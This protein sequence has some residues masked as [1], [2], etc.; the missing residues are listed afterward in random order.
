MT[1]S[2]LLTFIGIIILSFALVGISL[3][4]DA[5]PQASSTPGSQNQTNYTHTPPT[6]AYVDSTQSDLAVPYEGEL[7]QASPGLQGSAG[8]SGF[9]NPQAVLW[10]NGPLVTHP[11]A[12]AGM[13]ASR[14]QTDLGMNTLGF[15]HQYIQNY[16]M[17]DDFTISGPS[18]WNIQQITFF[19]YQTNSPISPSPFTGVYYQIWNGSPDDPGSSIVFGDLTTNRLVSSIFT[20][21]QRDSGTSNCAN[22][23]YIFAN[24][25]SAG[26]SLAPGTYWIEWM[27]D[28]N[29]SFSGPW[30]PPITILGQTT[31]GNALQYTTAWAPAL[32]SGTATQQGM[33]F[34]IEGLLGEPMIEVTPMDLHATQA[35]N[36]VTS[37]PLQICN[38]GGDTLNWSITEGYANKL[39]V[40]LLIETRDTTQTLQKA[41]NE[42]GIAYDLFQGDNWTGLDFSSYSVVIV[43]MDG[44]GINQPSL[45]KI[46]TD[47][48]DAG[49]RLVFV[50]GTCMQNFALGVNDFLVLNDTANYCWKIPNTPHFAIVDPANPLAFG[51]P[52]PYNFASSSAAYYQIRVNDPN[53][54]VVAINGD[55]FPNYFYK[56][57][58]FPLLNESNPL[59]TGDF[60]WFTNTPF[61][62]YWTD[63]GDYAFI[64]QLLS[65]ALQPGT[66][67]LGEPLYVSPVHLNTPVD[68]IRSEAGAT[69]SLGNSLPQIPLQPKPVG[70]IPAWISTSS[71]SAAIGTPTHTANPEAVLWD[72]PLSLVNQ[73]AYVNQEFGDYPTYSSYLADDFI[74]FAPWNISSIFIPGDGWNGFS[75]LFNA[76]AL[77]WQIYAD[78]GGV[79]AG[80]PSGG[81]SPP[82]WTLTLQPS[83]PQVII[84]NGTPGGYPSNVTLN[85]PS[86]V[87]LDPGHYWL[88]FYPGMDFTY[89]QYGRQPADTTNGYIAQFINPG[90]S[91]GY[92]TNWQ[93]WNIIGPTQ[94]D[95]AFRLEGE[96]GPLFDIPWLSENPISGSLEAGECVTVTVTFDSNRLPLGEYY[97]NLGVFSN[98]PSH[99]K[100]NV[101]VNLTVDQGNYYL[102][103]LLR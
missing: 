78:N 44:G 61:S 37:Q 40:V 8:S 11:A 98:D 35:T 80:D 71:N 36:T 46:R 26:V 1:K 55:G 92:G 93:N 79:P 62:T 86:P 58:D 67:D 48:I 10:D 64:K 29:P 77:T 5:S 38:V 22:N 21:I 69:S 32:D 17:A 42:L 53:I 18:G 96:I 72:Q 83:D 33:P 63:P 27:T 30:A 75:T 81:G 13:D 102:P 68:V 9:G 76:S 23:R 51:L 43:G 16:R 50:G 101:L 85:L 12:C 103:L 65:N 7:T 90:G 47:V 41:L 60:I 97:G 4:A 99:P 31:T 88:V 66:L 24:T 84:T 14:L 52:S 49:K 100:V 87:F 91:F 6:T 57:T 34:V 74:N 2:R 45:L 25:A 73:A 3:A 28:G 20:S 19:A 95:L 59:A 56:A 94:A 15:G 70:G 39:G 82:L 54:D 89:G